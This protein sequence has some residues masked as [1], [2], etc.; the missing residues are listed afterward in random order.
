M[1]YVSAGDGTSDSDAKHA[2][3]DL[4]TLPG[5]TLRIDVDRPSQGRLYGIPMD[6][7]FLGFEGARP[8]IWAYGL[9][10]PWRISFDRLTGDLWAGING[11][12]L[13]ETVQVVRRG[14]N[15]GWSITE[16]SHPFQSQRKRGPTPIVEPTIEHPHSEA[17]SITGGHVYSGLKFPSLRGHYIYGDYSTGTLWAAKY[18]D[19]KLRHTSKL[20]EPR[21]RLPVLVSITM[22][23]F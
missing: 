6:N 22:V 2:G 1:L 20:H 23:R 4:S 16:G 17:R 19:E 3:Q 7:P 13:W 9:R 15:Y 14:E 11:Q 12:D 8:E 5:S 18:R 10:N 21:C